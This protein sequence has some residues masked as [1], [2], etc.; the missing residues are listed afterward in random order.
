MKF[1]SWLFVSFYFYFPAQY[2]PKN[3]DI[4]AVGEQSKPFKP[5]IVYQDKGSLN[6]FVPSGYMPTGECIKMNDAWMDNCRS[7]SCIKVQY[8]IPCSLKGRHWAG[9]YWLKSGR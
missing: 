9:V 7:R 2:M 6:R 4:S 5:F 8:D 3:S 1:S